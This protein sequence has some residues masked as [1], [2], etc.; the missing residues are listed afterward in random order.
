MKTKTFL[1]ACLSLAFVTAAHAGVPCVDCFLPMKISAGTA[2]DCEPFPSMETMKREVIFKNGKPVFAQLIKCVVVKNQA[3]PEQSAF[4]GELVSGPASE[5][6]T[7][8]WEV[9][10][11]PGASGAVQWDTKDSGIVT[12]VADNKS[13]MRLIFKRDLSAN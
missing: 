3:V 4:V 10:Q 5:T 9:L 7:I 6:Y 8:S 11:F 12:T 13:H 2:V 1:S